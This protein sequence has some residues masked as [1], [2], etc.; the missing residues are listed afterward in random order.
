LKPHLSTK[1]GVFRI[2]G[3]P[4]L[5]SGY[6][7][8]ACRLAPTIRTLGEGSRILDTP[9]QIGLRK[10]YELAIQKPIVVKSTISVI[11]KEAMEA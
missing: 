8:H 4:Y 5:V 9:E 11:F 3:R 2:S 7:D 1:N 6:R 10:V